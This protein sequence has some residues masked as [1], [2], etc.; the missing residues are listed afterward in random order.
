MLN[1]KGLVS[2][3]CA[4]SMLLY[5]AVAGAQC[6]DGDLD[7]DGNVGVNELIRAVRSALDGCPT[8]AARQ[9]AGSECETDCPGDLDGDNEVTIAELIRA[10]NNAL[11]ACPIKTIGPPP[12]ATATGSQPVGPSA[13]P[14]ETP[15]ESPPPTGSQPVV[16][17]E[18]PTETPTDT[19]TN[20]PTNTSTPTD[21]PTKTSTPTDTP[22]NTHT[23][24]TTA[25][26]APPHT[27][28]ATHTEP[29]SPTPTQTP[30]GARFVDNGDGTISDNVTGLT[31]EKKS[32]DGGVHDRFKFYRWSTEF[33]SDTPDGTVFTE[34]LA[35]LNCTGEGMGTCA[36]LAGHRDW[37]L[38][39]L[40][41]LLELRE[42]GEDAISRVA[43][44]PF[45]LGCTE[46]CSVITCDCVAQQVHWTQSAGPPLIAG[47]T[48][49]PQIQMVDF[50]VSAS[51]LTALRLTN[52]SA[53]ARA[54]RGPSPGN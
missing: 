13:T 29:A 52:S 12:S 5:G 15:T 7:G 6:C 40:A 10:V 19:P 20:T 30:P 27:G 35:S 34:F 42:L 9:F 11:K 4:L 49:L 25:T 54:V 50:N 18:T 47:E 23:P 26:G 16:S 38:P 17:T 2:F 44:P 33:G 31:W 14:T 28:T 41:E 32:M 43:P 39:E 22:T 8:P 51:T 3:V 48:V 46:G 53:A 1:A 24:T 45:F 37:R 21:T 36:P